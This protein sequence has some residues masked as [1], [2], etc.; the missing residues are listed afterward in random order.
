M[1]LLEALLLDPEGAPSGIHYGRV[2]QSRNSALGCRERPKTP[3]LS[4]HRTFLP[5]QP[6]SI[7]GKN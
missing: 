5:S 3:T 6:F 1:S 4:A 2:A 7:S